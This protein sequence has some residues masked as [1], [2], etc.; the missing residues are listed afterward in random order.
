MSKRAA[1]WL[2]WFTW[3]LYVVI[4][5]V[6][7]L[8]QMKNA[9]LELPSDLFAPLVLLAF[10]T[11]GSL[12]ASRRPQN[13][14][15]WIFCISALLWTL[16][17]LL[18]QYTTY[19]FITVPGSLPA[20]A[21]LGV[22]GDWA[23]GM[24]WFLVLTFLLLLFPNG[25]L[26]SPRW[27]SL[28]WL[29][30]GL[31]A[32]YSIALLLSP[33]PY[34]NID[35]RLAA[36]RNPL[37]IL[38][39]NDLF[40]RLANLIL[41]LL[42]LTVLACIV[43]VV[44]R[45][46]R[47]RGVERQQL[48]WFAYGMTLCILML[49]VIIILMFSNVTS[50]PLATISFYLAVVCIP[51]SAGIAMLRYRLYDIDVLINR[52]LVYG[53]LTVSVV[54]MYVFVVGYLGTLFHKNGNLLIS[55]IAAGL[56][57]V[58]FQPL[59]ALL[60]RGVNRLLYGLRDEPYVVLARLGQRLQTTLDPDAIL[61][62]IVETVREALKLSY[63]AI[64]VKEGATFVLAASAGIP[65]AK[66][67]LRLPLMYH[68]ESLGTLLIAPRGRDEALTPTDLHLVHDLADQIGIAV[69]AVRLTSDLKRMATDVQ[70]SRERLVVA[71]EEERRRLRRDLHDGLGPTLAALALTASNVSDLI[72]TDPDAAVALANALQDDIRAT[73]RD[74]RRLVYEL[75][76]PALDELGLVGAI[77]ERAAQF[78]ST[79]QTREG[80]GTAERLQVHV[81]APGSLPPLSAAVEVAAYRIVQEAL[82]NVTRHAH[83]H[84]CTVRLSLTDALDIEITDDGIGLP[85][86]HQ[87]GVGL[88]SMRERAAEL[89]GLCIVEKRDGAGTRVYARL[90]VSKE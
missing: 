83:A 32:A 79:H 13:P 75:R 27:R 55:L 77:R 64:E 81:E 37:G 12:I 54:G 9:P 30:A 68:S 87:K 34:S 53:L 7:L 74:I 69:H 62:T 29:I 4:A 82:T 52:T 59:R 17:D 3:I 58:A 57:A 66:E 16:G 11:V 49:I 28:A 25:H 5:I 10:A 14:V 33:Y 56:V 65:P 24:G 44:L 26:P 61:S 71:R 48:K 86:E 89:G 70:R 1:F 20:G 18:L 80:L 19:A 67:A 36:V 90:P 2:A 73:V 46:R 8:F 23:R 38:V 50:G 60:Q 42:Y 63:A 22:F 45:F 21:L 84:A 40:D 85:Q 39:A 43:S 88:L 78:N 41:L 6:S 51:I 35:P 76:P 31:L 47:A 15:G 72:P